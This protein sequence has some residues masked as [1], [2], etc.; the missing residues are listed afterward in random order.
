MS[1]GGSSAWVAETVEN[2]TSNQAGWGVATMEYYSKKERTIDICN[3]MVKY[4]KCKII[5][6]SER[7][8]TKNKL[9]DPT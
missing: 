4:A 9:Y 5:M 3:I 1:D 7:N 6:L 8:Q 2:K